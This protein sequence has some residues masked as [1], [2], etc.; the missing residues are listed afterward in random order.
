VAVPS[1]AP[2]NACGQTGIPFIPPPLTPGPIAL[3]KPLYPF[4]SV[5]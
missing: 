5:K 4:A 1:S 3:L 2:T